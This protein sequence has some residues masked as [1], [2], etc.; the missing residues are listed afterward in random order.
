MVFD[1]L[2]FLIVLMALAGDKDDI[3]FLCQHD[4]RLNRFLAVGYR[5]HFLHLLGIQASQHVIDDVLWLFE[6]GIVGSNDNA[7]ALLDSLLSHQRTLA[8]VTV[9]TGTANGDYLS[10]LAVKYL[11]NGIEHILQGV[12]SV[13][14]VHNGCHT[15]L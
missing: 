7:V 10:A 4:S 3:A 5:D 12:G 15:V 8:L 2:D 1:A 13:G 11:M 14:I 9:A 6:P